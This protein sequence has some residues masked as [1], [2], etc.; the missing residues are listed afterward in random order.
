MQVDIA[1]MSIFD[2]NRCDVDAY[3]LSNIYR[4]DYYTYKDQCSKYKF[5]TDIRKDAASKI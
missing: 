1:S 3:V 4:I 5:Y 2:R